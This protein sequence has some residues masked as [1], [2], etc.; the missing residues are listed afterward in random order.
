M[1]EDSRSRPSHSRADVLSMAGLCVS[2]TQGD[3]KGEG[4]GPETGKVTNGWN[5]C[6]VRCLTGGGQVTS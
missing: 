6:F 2:W 5:W 3:F 1:L 4:E